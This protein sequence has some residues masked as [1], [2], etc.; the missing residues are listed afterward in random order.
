MVTL[1][2]ALIG[3]IVYRFS[4]FD[5]NSAFVWRVPLDLKIYWLAGGEVAQGA[6]L[7]D[8]AYIGDLPFTYPPFSGTLFTWLSTLDDAPSVS[9][10]HLTLPTN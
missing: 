5:G 9:Y 7:Y 6:D 3:V 2:A 10:T 8:N 4:I 1:L